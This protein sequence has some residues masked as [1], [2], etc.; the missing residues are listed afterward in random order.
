MMLLDWI[1][2]ISTSVAAL[3]A[4]A[5]IVASTLIMRRDHGRQALWDRLQH[6][7]AL[8]TAFEDVHGMATLKWQADEVDIDP[9]DEMRSRTRYWALL[10]ASSEVLP[11]A[12]G[13]AFRHIPFGA[14]DPGESAYYKAASMIGNPE[15]D[16]E[17][18]MK[19]RAE[20]VAVLDELRSELHGPTWS[21]PTWRGRPLTDGHV[22]AMPGRGDDRGVT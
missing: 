1:T 16:D 22:S 7:T 9:L 11:I 4:V 18:T 2:A 17:S 21:Q 15:T 12:R 19:I 14:D 10:R 20:I 3:A 5:A 8:L 6:A 13:H